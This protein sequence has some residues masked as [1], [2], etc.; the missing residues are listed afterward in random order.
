[1]FYSLKMCF[2]YVLDYRGVKQL[3]KKIIFD[4]VFLTAATKLKINLFQNKHFSFFLKKKLYISGKVIKKLDLQKLLLETKTKA[5]YLIDNEGKIIDFYPQDNE[6][7]E[8]K[9]KIAAFDAVIFN[10]SS[11]FF[12]LFF[13]SELNEITLKSEKEALLLYKYKEY[14]LCFLADK[15]TNIGL[16]NILLKKEAN[17]INFNY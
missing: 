1:M 9:D 3:R 2:V 8:I 11:S 12:N 10:M 5:I 13:N 17:T 16:L 15:S 7:A 4:E 14:V 6:L